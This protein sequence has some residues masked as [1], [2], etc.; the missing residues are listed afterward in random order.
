MSAN[1]IIVVGAGAFGLAASLELAQR[2]IRPVIV[3]PTGPTPHSLAASRDISKV[4]RSEYGGDLTYTR[5]AQKSIERWIQLNERWGRVYH[6]TGI[7]WLSSCSTAGK[8]E[9]LSARTARRLNIDM[10]M[11]G[12]VEIGERWPMFNH[13]LLQRGFF[14]PRG[15]FVEARKVLEHMRDELNQ[16]EVEWHIGQSVANLIL[17]KGRCLG[18]VLADGV[19]LEADHV[20]VAAGAWTGLLVPLVSRLARATAQPIFHLRVEDWNSYSSPRFSVAFLDMEST[21]VYAMPLHPEEKVIKVGLHTQGHEAHPQLSDRIVQ[22]QEINY[23]RRQL[24]R[25][26]PELSKCPIVYTRVCLYHDTLDFDFVIDLH[27]EIEN[28]TVACGGSGHG[29][30][31]TPL[32]G[33][34]IADCVE[35]IHNPFANKFKWREQANPDESGAIARPSL[36]FHRVDQ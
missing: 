22:E 13:R 30:K 6:N 24:D 35:G 26:A 34:L 27:P 16:L 15:G 9:S 14:N 3:D 2:G 21:G 23:L 12:A 19:R 20:L 25:C 29:F 4:V 5:M 36:E 8:F 18:V 33:E 11:L 1:Q 10:E 31:F 32:L 17:T 28:L 7:A